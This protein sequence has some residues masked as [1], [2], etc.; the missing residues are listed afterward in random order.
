MDGEP[1]DGEVAAA[2]GCGLRALLK[3]HVTPSAVEALS[4]GGP[5]LLRPGCNDDDD[6]HRARVFKAW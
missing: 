1:M 3:A 5:S 4:L 6:G 2:V